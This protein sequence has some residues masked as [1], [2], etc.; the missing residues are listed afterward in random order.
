MVESSPSNAALDFLALWLADRAAGREQALAAY[1]AQFVG[2]EA[3]V[4]TEWLRAHQ[5][6]AA[7]SQPAEEAPGQVANFRLIRELGRGGQGRVWLAHDPP[8]LVAKRGAISSN[9]RLMS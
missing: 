6:P 1:Q 7:K 3:L 9:K 8:G 5:T 2:H 4:E